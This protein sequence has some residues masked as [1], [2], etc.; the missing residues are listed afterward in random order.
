MVSIVLLKYNGI[1]AEKETELRKH[2]TKSN[3]D[4]KEYKNNSNSVK[5]QV[6]DFY[7]W[8]VKDFLHAVDRNTMMFG[9]E[10][11]TPFLDDE[12]YE[13]ARKLPMYAKI[14]KVMMDK[15]ASTATIS[16]HS[17]ISMPKTKSVSAAG[18]HHPGWPGISP[19]Y[20]LSGY[21]GDL[22]LPG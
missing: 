9:L 8:L 17:S 4:Y 22:F 16:P 3:V 21:S 20:R 13:V 6:I 1:D 14:D 11:R 12:V 5:K 19:A 15:I 2:L 7:F 10:A 18:T